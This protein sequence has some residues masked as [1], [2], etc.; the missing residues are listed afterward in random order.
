MKF[1]IGK[2]YFILKSVI[3]EI[4]REFKRIYLISKFNSRIISMKIRLYTA[5]D[6]I[7]TFTT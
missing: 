4:V 2:S 5:L 3:M 7:Y 6:K 1:F